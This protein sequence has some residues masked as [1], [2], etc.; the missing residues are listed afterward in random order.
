MMVK[1]EEQPSNESC[2]GKPALGTAIAVCLLLSG[3]LTSCA[4]NG[5]T[6][7]EINYLIDT[8]GGS[9]CAFIRNDEE[10]DRREAREPLRSKL[11]LNAQLV[12]TTE[13]FITLIASESA[14]TGRPYQIRCP[15][16]EPVLANT[17]FSGLLMEYRQGF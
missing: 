11:Q 7:G 16:Q 10:L 1:T 8:V 14:D 15:D 2:R 12:N 17:W 6:S 5:A 9:R 13:D 3:T 4:S